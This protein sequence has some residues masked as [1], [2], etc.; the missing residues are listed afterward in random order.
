VRFLRLLL[1]APYITPDGP[2]NANLL[3]G[4]KGA[5]Q[6]IDSQ[7]DAN[8]EIGVFLWWAGAKFVALPACLQ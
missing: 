1:P 2:G 5:G 8:R 4:G 7:E 3:I 6:E